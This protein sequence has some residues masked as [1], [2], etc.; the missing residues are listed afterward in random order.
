[1]ERIEYI[2]WIDSA[3]AHE[4]RWYDREVLETSEPLG[5]CYTCG[6]LIGETDEHL[7]FAH[8][9]CEAEV[10]PYITIPKVA[11]RSRLLLGEETE[12]APPADHHRPCSCDSGDGGA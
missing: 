1:L 11:I 4:Q 2:V 7:T 5:Y 3:A 10:G 12:A 8:T 6:F 9:V